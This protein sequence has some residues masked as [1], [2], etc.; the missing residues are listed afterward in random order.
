VYQNQA[1][2]AQSAMVACNHLSEDELQMLIL[3]F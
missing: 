2:M 3:V 1:S